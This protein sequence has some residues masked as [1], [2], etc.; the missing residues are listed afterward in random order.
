VFAVAKEH[1]ADFVFIYVECYTEQIAGK[2]HQFIIADTRKASDLG[3]ADGDA[4][5]RAHL[6]R[7][8]LRREDFQRTADSRERS[9][10]DRMQTIKRIT[11]RTT[12]AA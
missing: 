10:E 12:F 5:D 4:H 2:L 8:Q 3:D 9:I 11:Q 6:T 1:D 7:R